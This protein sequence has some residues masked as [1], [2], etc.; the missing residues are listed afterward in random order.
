M[1]L[2]ALAEQK[3]IILVFHRESMM[4][5]ADRVYRMEDGEMREETE[6]T[7]TSGRDKFKIKEEI[8]I[9]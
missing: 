1:I 5:I 2:K 6:M 4:A 7:L 8:Q 3:T 9:C